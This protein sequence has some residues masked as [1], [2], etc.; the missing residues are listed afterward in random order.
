MM[1]ELFASAILLVSLAVWLWTR[2]SQR[3]LSMPGRDGLP[4]LGN[5][6]QVDPEKPHFTFTDWA[7]ELG[8]VFCVRLC[9]KN[10]VV[11]NGFAAV[12]EVLVE[13]GPE[14]AGRPRSFTVK[15]F[16]NNFRNLGF[17]NPCPAWKMLRRAVQRDL[18]VFGGGLQRLENIT[19]KITQEL[20]E[21][22]A[23]V[24]H[25]GSTAFDVRPLLYSA[26]MNIMC[27]FLVGVRYRKTDAEFLLFQEMERLGVTLIASAGKGAELNA[28]PWLRWFGNETFERLERFSKLRDELYATLKRRSLEEEKKEA[29]SSENGGKD[30]AIIPS[31]LKIVDE[32]GENEDG[33]DEEFI[34]GTFSDLILGGTASTTNLIYA[35]LN[36]MLHYPDVYSK[37]RNEVR[38][39]VATSDQSELPHRPG[40]ADKAALPFTQASILELLRYVSIAP[41][42]VPHQSLVD[43]TIAGHKVPR[44]TEVL[45]N[46]WAVMH[47]ETLWDEPWRFRPERF[48]T[49]DGSAVVPP[50]HPNR[51]HLIAFGAGPRHCIG[52]VFALSRLFLIVTSL[53]R[54][55]DLLRPGHDDRRGT[56]AAADEA[57]LVPCDPRSYSLGIALYP[58]SYKLRLVPTTHLEEKLRKASLRHHYRA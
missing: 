42:T 11:A 28:F 53:L 2:R 35:Y 45:C 17:C 14:F 8:D 37:V 23:T 36:I 50:E 33:F 18:K 7:K 38:D 19:A 16:T 49:E 25:G 6:L 15:C 56:A 31:L 48:L 40:L 27:V 29:K 4:V 24:G 9:G 47:D 55:F 54:D 57:Q 26:T 20:S 13:K 52:E 21:E 3:R 10:L 43:T 1:S 46:L 30:R 32:M 5:L 34:K 51:R 12:H 41:F 22:M 39:L 44:D 58:Q